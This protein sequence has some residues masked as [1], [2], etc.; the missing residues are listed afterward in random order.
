MGT[1]RRKRLEQQRQE[2]LFRE[3]AEGETPEAIAADPGAAL[4]D[5]EPADAA[6]PADA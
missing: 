4:L 6:D 3:E 1:R 5:A 2:P